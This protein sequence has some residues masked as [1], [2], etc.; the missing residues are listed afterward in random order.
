MAPKKG[1]AVML[2]SVERPPLNE[3]IFNLKFEPLS[4]FKAPHFGWY[5]ER[6]AG[7]YP[8]I[9]QKI[10]IGW[11]MQSER[12]E[13]LPNP[14]VWF[15]DEKGQTL[16]Q[17]QDDRFIF[18]WRKTEAEY[19]YLRFSELFPKFK[20]NFEN[21]SEFI[22]EKNLGEVKPE[23]CELTYLNQIP[24]DEIWGSYSEIQRVLP[25]LS[26]RDD[27]ERFLSGQE[28]FL[29]QTEFPLPENFGSGIVKVNSAIRRRDQHPM[30]ILELHALGLGE[31]KSLDAVWRWF[32]MAHAWI[33]TAFFDLTSPEMH[34]YWG[35]QDA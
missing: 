28:K 22:K 4:D 26:W 12:L 5:W 19:E 34:N 21:F 1:D 20:E 14:R 25:D 8:N 2:P 10:P 24:M 31:D 17:L 32:G 9:D 6:I 11:P 30:I 16:I 29:W 3:V 18:N 13:I 7:E 33:V 15:L 23:S 27:P 35:R